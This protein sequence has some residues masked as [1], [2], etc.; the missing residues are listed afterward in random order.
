V[1]ETG[2]YGEDELLAYWICSSACLIVLRSKSWTLLITS[3]S[4]TRDTN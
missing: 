1:T 4:C 3:T 2:I